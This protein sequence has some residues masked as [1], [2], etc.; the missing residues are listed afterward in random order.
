MK[1]N[2]RQQSY[3]ILYG[4]TNIQ[5]LKLILRGIYWIKLGRIDQKPKDAYCA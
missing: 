1:V 4:K 3:Q 2:A 5:A